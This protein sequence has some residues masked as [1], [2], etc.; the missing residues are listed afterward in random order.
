MMII[1]KN[2]EFCHE[3]VQS[4]HI[5]V[6]GLRQ[7]NDVT[8]S[9]VSYERMNDHTALTKVSERFAIQLARPAAV[10]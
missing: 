10:N 5:I 2:H 1:R 3:S 9:L 8:K 7:S 4:S 6:E